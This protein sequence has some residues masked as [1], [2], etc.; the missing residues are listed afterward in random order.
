MPKEVYA[1]FQQDIS[2]NT[3]S[4]FFPKTEIWAVVHSDKRTD[5]VKIT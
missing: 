2:K 1:K 3:T 4:T 5:I